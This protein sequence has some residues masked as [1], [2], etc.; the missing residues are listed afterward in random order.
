MSEWQPIETAPRDGTD[1]DLWDQNGRQTE[2][3]WMIPQAKEYSR[4]FVAE[5]CY[6]HVEWG[7]WVELG[8][9]PTHW[10]PLPASPCA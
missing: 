2:C 9:H 1:V 7:E 8:G 5:W 4:R 6:Y 10:M 3:R